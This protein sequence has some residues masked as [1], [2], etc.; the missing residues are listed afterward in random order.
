MQQLRG[1]Q[2]FTKKNTILLAGGEPAMIK[3]L[4]HALE[5][6]GF[7]VVIAGDSMTVLKLTAK[8][9]SLTLVVLDTKEPEQQ[10]IEVCYRLREFSKVP[11]II[12]GATYE[13]NDIVRGLECGAD[14]YITKPFCIAEFVARVKA[15]LRCSDFRCNLRRRFDTQATVGSFVA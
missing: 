8:R 1:K 7:Q 9:K 3:L 2:M 13:E 4:S 10:S 5:T 15:V 14:E 11:V 12:L 6:E